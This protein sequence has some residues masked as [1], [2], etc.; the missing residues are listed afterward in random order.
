MFSVTLFGYAIA[1]A[2]NKASDVMVI[3]L[4]CKYTTLQALC[5]LLLPH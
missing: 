2:Q 3:G 1:G 4:M 5:D